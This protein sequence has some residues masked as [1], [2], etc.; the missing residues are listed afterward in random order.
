[1]KSRLDVLTAQIDSLSTK[2]EEKDKEMG[3]QEKQLKEMKNMNAALDN[4]LTK[5]MDA[6]ELQNKV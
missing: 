6:L 4:Q 1:M 3:F 5:Y 2:L